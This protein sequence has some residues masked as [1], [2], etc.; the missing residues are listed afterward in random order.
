MLKN[1]WSKYNQPNDSKYKWFHE[2]VRATSSG[3]TLNARTGKAL[4]IEGKGLTALSKAL[5]ESCLLAQNPQLDLLL[6]PKIEDAITKT[7]MREWGT[8]SYEFSLEKVMANSQSLD[9]NQKLIRAHFYF[10]NGN[11]TQGQDSLQHIK[12]YA[13][14]GGARKVL[15][16]ILNELRDNNGKIQSIS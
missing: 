12:C 14:W 13:E 7:L 8:R 6:Q 1:L 3:V 15:E 10:G 5:A 9:K 4:D 16:F 11:T 2:G